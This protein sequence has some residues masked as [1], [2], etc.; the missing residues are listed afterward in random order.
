MF[1]ID[2]LTPWSLRALP[3][4]QVHVH[5]K[6]SGISQSKILKSASVSEDRFSQAGVK[7]HPVDSITKGNRTAFFVKNRSTF[8]FNIMKQ[9]FFIRQYILF[10]RTLC[11]IKIWF[12]SDICQIWSDIVRYPT[13]IC[14]PVDGW[15]NEWMNSKKIDM[16]AVS[17]SLDF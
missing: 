7:I 4:W 13:V 11:P 14:S 10:G 2:W 16:P 8:S 6:L 9:T 1:F 5:V 12:C 15:M 17:L 3:D